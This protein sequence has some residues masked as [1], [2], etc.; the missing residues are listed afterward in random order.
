MAKQ[1]DVTDVVL[2][3]VSL[4]LIGTRSE[5]MDQIQGAWAANYAFVHLQALGPDGKE[6]AVS[7]GILQATGLM[8]L[9]DHKATLLGYGEEPSP[10]PLDP[11]EVHITL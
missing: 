2:Q 1:I 10:E 7:L 6:Y 9:G 3:G 8:V 5:V 4:H 11:N